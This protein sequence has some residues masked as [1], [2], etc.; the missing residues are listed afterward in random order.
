AVLFI[1]GLNGSKFYTLGQAKVEED[2]E[3]DFHH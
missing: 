2:H 1:L 3:Q